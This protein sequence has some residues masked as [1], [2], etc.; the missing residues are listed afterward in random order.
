MANR[1][2]GRKHNGELDLVNLPY[3]KFVDL[4]F[5]PFA[6]AAL[7]DDPTE[8]I[9]MVAGGWDEIQREITKRISEIQIHRHLK[10]ANN[11]LKYVRLMGKW[12][13][14]KPPALRYNKETITFLC[15]ARLDGKLEGT[16][17]EVLGDD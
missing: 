14:I 15:R 3:A 8:S 17:K 9:A 16:W 11:Q 2:E 7:P 6:V 5:Y 12:F 1:A 4:P 13:N 10:W